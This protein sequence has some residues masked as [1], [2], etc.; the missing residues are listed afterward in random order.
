MK[1]KAATGPRQPA[2]AYYRVSTR[3]QGDSRLGLDA[4]RAA[5]EAFCENRDLVVAKSFEDIETGKH[6]NRPGLV[7]AIQASKEL[8]AKLLIAKLD[9]L[10]RDVE[11]IWHL[12]N[13]GVDF[14]A[15]DLPEANTLTISIM[16]ALA[17][18]ERE[19]ISGRTRAALAVLKTRG[20]KLGSPRNLTSSARAKGRAARTAKSLRHSGG[21]AVTALALRSEGWGL[22]RIA[23]T[24]NEAGHRTPRNRRY[25]P[26]AVWRILKARRG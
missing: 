5:V 15:I 13:T 10:S 21:A 8:G 1:Q 11:F 9:R 17:Q 16:A 12:R 26:T 6:N 3:E 4:Q 25:T 18:H 2:V 7:A 19:L 23:K 14:V 20:K 22:A 24:L